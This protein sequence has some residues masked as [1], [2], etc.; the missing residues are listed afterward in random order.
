MPTKA[1]VPA[2][3]RRQVFKEGNYTC[4]IC[5]IKGFERKFSRGGYGHYTDV[6]NVYLSID[7]IIP[8]SKG[9][10]GERENLRVL[11]TICNSRKGVKD[12]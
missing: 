9:G 11:C 1:G 8:R 4:A 7:H 6:R 5:G 2:P 10:T 3:L 12:A